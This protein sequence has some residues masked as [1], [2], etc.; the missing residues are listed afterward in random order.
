[1]PVEEAVMLE[2]ANLIYALGV[3]IEAAHKVGGAYADT[4]VVWC[5]LE[6]IEDQIRQLYQIADGDTAP[7][8]CCCMNA[9][10]HCTKCD[11]CGGHSDKYT[12]PTPS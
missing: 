7:T 3:Y 5:H 4:Q 2:C 1:M 11:L 6:T 8:Q 10:Q 12:S 9:G